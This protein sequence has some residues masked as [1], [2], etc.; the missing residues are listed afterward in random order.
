MFYINISIISYWLKQKSIKKQNWLNLHLRK[1]ILILWEE[2]VFTKVF[3]ETACQKCTKLC[4]KQKD[5]ILN[6]RHKIQ[7]S[8]NISG[9][10]RISHHNP[11][12][13]VVQFSHVQ[14]HNLGTVC[15][16]L[17]RT[18]LN[19]YKPKLFL[20]FQLITLRYN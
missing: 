12:I 5:S 10:I 17:T 18:Q 7:I 8:Y 20:N 6:Q 16:I 13:G 9:D 2:L 3:F 11:K 1:L 14:H 4:R 19:I 15:P